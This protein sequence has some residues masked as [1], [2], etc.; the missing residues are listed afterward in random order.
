MLDFPQPAA[1]GPEGT[2]AT[3]SLGSGDR[4]DIPQPVPAVTD[5]SA[6]LGQMW[7]SGSGIGRGGFTNSCVGASG[8]AIP[9]DAKP[10]G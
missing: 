5:I 9:D 2:T 3:S 6:G 8:Q 1:P 10:I 4:I 7:E